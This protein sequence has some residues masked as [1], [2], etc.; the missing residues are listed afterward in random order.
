M[1]ETDPFNLQRFV[2]AQ[3]RCYE[4]VCRELRAGCKS[5]HWMWFIFPQWKGL[6]QSPTANFYAIASR[7]EAEAYLTH[8]ILGPRLRE[9]TQLVNGVE[10]RAVDEIFGYPDDL[11]FLSSMTLF[12]NVAIDSDSFFRALGKFFG[13]KPDQRTLDLMKRQTS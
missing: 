6:G 10:G 2:D 1:S 3:N 12:A 7:R 13:G 4:Q 5:S 9:C 8:P 11:K